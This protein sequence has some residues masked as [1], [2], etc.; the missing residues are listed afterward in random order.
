MLRPRTHD[1][2]LS[3]Y[4]Q[5]SATALRRRE[6]LLLSGAAVTSLLPGCGGGNGSGG[7]IATGLT[8]VPRT[9]PT[10]DLASQIDQFSRSVDSLSLTFGG[11]SSDVTAYKNFLTGAGLGRD[12]AP[13][14]NNYIQ[15]HQLMLPVIR[16]MYERVVNAQIGL[17]DTAALAE[18]VSSKNGL[19]GAASLVNPQWT[20]GMM[21]LQHAHLNYWRAQSEVFQ[22]N[23]LYLI[24]EATLAAT[25]PLNMK[26]LYAMLVKTHNDWV[27][28]VCANSRVTVNPEWQLDL[29]AG[30]NAANIPAQVGRLPTILAQV[31]MGPGYRDAVARNATLPQTY[32]SFYGQA[33]AS[34]FAE[35]FLGS[36]GPV[37]F[38]MSDP[39]GFFTKLAEGDGP[40]LNVI[41]QLMTNLATSA[42]G[43][44]F[45]KKANCIAKLAVDG[46]NLAA[47]VV[48]AIGTSETIVGSVIFGALALAQACAMIDT[49]RECLPALGITQSEPGK[50]VL[51]F[52]Q[53]LCQKK[54]PTNRNIPAY[55]MQETTECDQIRNASVFKVTIP[56]PGPK[57]PLD[58]T[59]SPI[60]TLRQIL[61]GA[62]T[63]LGG[64]GSRAGEIPIPR[65]YANLE[66][67][68]LGL[69]YDLTKRN[70]DTL[71]PVATATSLSFFRAETSI[72]IRREPGATASNVPA[73]TDAQLLCSAPGF[74]PSRSTG[75]MDLTQ[76]P[77]FPNLQALSS[78]A[79]GG[80][81]NVK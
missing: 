53:Q 19:K 41:P 75:D 16:G 6:F 70:V 71:Q 57:P 39:K 43:E 25:T 42:I 23:S 58:Y 30:V 2:N 5:D 28:T 29:S 44:V 1:D 12:A 56:V 52:L 59:N 14:F 54:L 37:S 47:V 8:P 45:G 46:G 77:S 72:L 68:S 31:P 24:G 74:I 66:L 7:T 51:D 20:A 33:A 49:W 61:C 50:K 79:P 3:E 73:I 63:G 11:T 32:G 17:D 27:D 48:A 26:L 9:Q 55:P 21:D 15:I 64:R 22:T 4:S 40:G 76:I 36:P 81:I 38:V 10:G 34:A 78:I 67:M 65:T 35:N 69:L 80:Q 62:L 60:D 18:A 13:D